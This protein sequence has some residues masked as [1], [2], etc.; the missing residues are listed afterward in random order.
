METSL[1]ATLLP[2]ARLRALDAELGSMEA[3]LTALRY[4]EGDGRGVIPWMEP[5]S[6]R[7][8]EQVCAAL[9]FHDGELGEDGDVDADEVR[10]LMQA[11][12]RVMRQLQAQRARLERVL[13]L[14]DEVA[15]AVGSDMMQLAMELH[16]MLCDAGRADGI[17][18]L[19]D[20]RKRRRRE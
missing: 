2:D 6:P 18:A 13:A 12:L 19:A 4:A 17:T 5:V 10:A 11:E 15:G 8:C 20:M 3:V 9:D 14:T 16:G 7:L 1:A